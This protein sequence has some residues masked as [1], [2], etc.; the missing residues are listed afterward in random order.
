MGIEIRTWFLTSKK[1]TQ[2]EDQ[3]VDTVGEEGQGGWEL[4]L[5]AADLGRF[6][7][8]P[9][10]PCAPNELRCCPATAGI[11]SPGTVLVTHPCQHC[12]FPGNIFF[13]SSHREISLS[14]AQSKGVTSHWLLTHFCSYTC[15]KC[16]TDSCP[17][18][19]L[20]CTFYETAFLFIKNISWYLQLILRCTHKISFIDRRLDRLQIGMR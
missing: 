4:I 11:Y 12:L 5:K 8:W 16:P 19:N 3:R 13:D 1:L 20:T 14:H 9:Q 15:K 7:F 6:H 17:C 18:P 10:V 2:W